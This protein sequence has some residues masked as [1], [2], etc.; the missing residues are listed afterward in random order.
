ME[1]NKEILSAFNCPSCDGVMHPPIK[2]CVLGHCICNPCFTKN[3]LCPVCNSSKSSARNFGLEELYENFLFHC[4]NK[5]EGCTFVGEGAVTKDHEMYC[6]YTILDCPLKPFLCSWTGTIRDLFDHTKKHHPG[7]AYDMSEKVIPLDMCTHF[8]PGSF[9]QVVI[10]AFEE[11][12][13]FMCC[14]NSNNSAIKWVLLYL[15]SK[16]NANKFYYT[17]EFVDPRDPLKVVRLKSN[18]QLLRN[19]NEGVK[20]KCEILSDNDVF[21]KILETRHYHYIVTLQKN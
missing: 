10:R 18:C 11:V 4:E 20:I 1:A 13:L 9:Y 21:K 2:M 17:V 19:Y 16:E 8:V 14:V 5:D 3:H 7:N 12:F 6:S 15:G